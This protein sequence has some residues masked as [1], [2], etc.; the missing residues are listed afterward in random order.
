MIIFELFWIVG[1]VRVIRRGRSG[2]IGR[3]ER[4]F[5]DGSNQ[6]E[7]GLV[8]LSGGGYTCVCF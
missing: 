3:G 5:L 6:H 1:A 2:V 4:W 7:G 8:I